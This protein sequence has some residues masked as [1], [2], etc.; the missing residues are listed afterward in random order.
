M[1]CIVFG[2]D[3]TAACL[4]VEAMNDAG[5]LFPANPRQSGA[6]VKER[7][8][9]SM[10]AMTSA[11]MNNKARRLVQHNEIIV[12]EENLKRDLSLAGSSIFSS[13]GSVS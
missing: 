2:D 11:R 8:D 4:L 9:Q 12:F 1:G 13:G 6:V 7:I 10:F 5:T 3:K